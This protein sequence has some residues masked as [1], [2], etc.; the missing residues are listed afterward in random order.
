M[1]APDL[2]AYFAARGVFLPT[3]SQLARPETLPE[4]VT[5]SLARVDPD[6][7]DPQ[8][9]FR[10]HWFNAPDRRGI[11]AVPAHFVVPKALT[12]VDAPIVVLLGDRFPMIRAHK[13]LA[14]YGCLMPRLAEGTFDPAHHRALWPSTGNYCRGGVAISRVLGCRGVAILPEGM[15]RERFEWLSRWVT[16]PDDVVRTPGTESNV[17]EIYDACARLSADPANVIL[18]QFSEIANHLTHYRVTGAAL[19]AVLRHLQVGQPELRAAA[20]VS[21]TG[22]AG[23]IG[24][25]DALKE[26]HGTKIVAV[27][28][29]ECPT[30]LLNGH[31][32]HNIQG[33]GDKHIPLIHN[34][35]NTDAVVAVSDQATDRL[36]VLLQSAAGRAFLSRELQLAPEVLEA[37][38][39]FG[40]SS[41]CNVVAAIKTVKALGLGPNDA[42]LT[43]ATDGA[44]LYSSEVAAVLERSY[45][46]A[47]TEA[48]AA[49]TFERY[50][51][52]AGTDHVLE[53]RHEDRTRIFNL[54][55]FTW[56]EQQGVPVEAFDARREQAWWQAQRSKLVGWD[57]AISELNE[58]IAAARGRA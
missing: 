39:H 6:A 20:F 16:S 23:T 52:G 57:A 42:V 50:L 8:N 15:S 12:G 31:G 33:I 13:V 36:M 45:S 4:D 11:A 53:L 32:S 47:L 26:R 49:S 48:A 37:F 2:A 7:P 29:V 3:L 22:S 18:N 54:G 46:G 17:K 56:V 58:R 44:D 14:A 5:A 43:I 55:Y 30:M 34:V 19:G 51:L 1:N 40:L 25:G 24:A 38:D 21:A 28:P 10:V 35:M 9:L 27:E 41:L